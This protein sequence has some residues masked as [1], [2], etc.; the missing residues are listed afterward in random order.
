VQEWL[1]T[2]TQG[3]GLAIGLTLAVASAAIGI[4]VARNW[5]ARAFLGLSVFINLGFWIV[6]QGFGG[7]FT[8]TATDPNSGPLLILL[9]CALYALI[10]Q[11]ARASDPH[12]QQSLDPSPATR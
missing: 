8:G 2:A 12:E 5:H 4:A 11:P 1:A 7:L 10:D 6:G 9:A 3:H